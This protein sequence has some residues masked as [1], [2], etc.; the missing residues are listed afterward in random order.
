MFS[1]T[2]STKLFFSKKSFIWFSSSSQ[3]L[4]VK[5]F[6]DFT[7]KELGIKFK[8]KGKGINEK[9][10]DEN[11]KIIVACDKAYYRPLEVNTLLGNS[12]K[13]RK[14]L[15]WSPKIN[16]NELIAEMIEFEMNNISY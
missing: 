13:A 1:L 6:V 9:A 3:T 2:R 11:G 10:V 4:W 8:W 7:L 15:K 16:L 5:Q 14:K 12:G